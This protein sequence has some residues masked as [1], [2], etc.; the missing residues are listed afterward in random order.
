M[1]FLPFVEQST[2]ELVAQL[3]HYYD[4]IRK[5]ATESLLE[6]VR[7]FYDIQN[8]AEWQPGQAVVV[9]LD[10]NVKDLIE[11]VLPPMFEMYESEDN[12]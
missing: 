9:P 11:H 12:K 8:P 2:I 4:G 5:A 10:Q 6:I 7:T 3:S 1:H